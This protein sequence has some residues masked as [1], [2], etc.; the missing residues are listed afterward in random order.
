MTDR[1]DWKALYQE[2][3]RQNEIHLEEASEQANLLILT[4]TRLA[5]AA[6]GLDAQLDPHLKAI[7]DAVRDGASPRL[8]ARLDDLSDSLM[9]FQEE[10]ESAAQALDRFSDRLASTLHLSRQDTARLGRLLKALLTRPTQVPEEDLS[11]LI[12]LLRP[13]TSALTGARPG[14]FGKLLT[15]GSSASG[16]IQAS[17]NR[18]LLNLLD[19]AS[20]PGHW[21]VEITEFKQ[22]LS[23][24]SAENEWI[25][26]LEDLL[27]LSARSYG[28]AK[29]EIR[30]AEDFLGELTQR[31]QDLDEHLRSVR[32]GRTQAAEQSRKMGK[33]VTS[34]VGGLYSTVNAAM[35]ITE[36]K[37]EINNRLQGLQQTMDL[38]LREEQQWFQR[39]ESS[40]QD[41]RERLHELDTESQELRQRLLEAHHLALRDAVTELPNRMA[42]DERVEQEFARWKR[43]HGH[44]CMLV[45]D[46]DN[47]KS[48]ND[49]FGHQAGDKAL[50]VIAKCLQK[51]LRET[52]FIARYGGEE[53]VA[54]LCGA[55]RDKALQVAEQMRESVMQSGFHAGGKAVQITISCGLAHFTQ[56]DSVESVFKRAD[57]AVYQAKRK[58]KNRCEIG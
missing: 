15:S 57:E 20:W 22:R 7:R 51:R 31:L 44:L 36:L 9:R 21:G 23:A 54:L 28:E 17:I 10:S 55:D 35:D 50:R 18:K 25:T 43:F 26:V 38:F 49:R 39:V 12:D 42:Y 6:S 33:S 58:G 34:Q 24:A 53:F 48:I 47:F 46:V 2:L 29:A 8:K 11:H 52:D 1:T 27:E 45:W 19:Q 5:L 40:E 14:L 32:E 37:Q 13:E 41:L 3:L 56:G 4:I 16:Q 30:E